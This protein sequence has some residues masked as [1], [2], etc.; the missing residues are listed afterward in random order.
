MYEWVEIRILGLVFGLVHNVC[1]C[2]NDIPTYL[3][4]PTVLEERSAPGLSQA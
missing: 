3:P 4:V 1:I 2:A